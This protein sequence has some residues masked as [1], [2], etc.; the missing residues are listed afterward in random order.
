MGERAR[1]RGGREG[2]GGRGREGG[3]E[4]ERDQR[5]GEREM[6]YNDY[7]FQIWEHSHRSNLHCGFFLQKRAIRFIL[8]TM[9]QGHT[10]AEQIEVE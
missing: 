4:G 1:G 3:R 6:T 7:H 10:D 5:G 2:E 9:A 8:V